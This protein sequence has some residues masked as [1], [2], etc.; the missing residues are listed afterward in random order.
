MSGICSAHQGHSPD[1]PLCNYVPI[2]RDEPWTPPFN[3][4]QIELLQRWQDGEFLMHPYTCNGGMP[5]NEHRHDHEVLLMPTPHGM[6]C[7]ECGRIQTVVL[8]FKIGLNGS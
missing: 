7:P 4:D 1:C 3:W 8:P 2:E 5:V 6:R